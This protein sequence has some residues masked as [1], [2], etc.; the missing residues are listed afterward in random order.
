ME[1]L[2]N[3]EIENDIYYRRELLINSVEGRRIDLL[4][5]SSFHNIQKEREFHFA[6]LFP[7]ANAIRC[8]KFESKKVIF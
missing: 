5:I 4:T 7:E 1:N 6:D 8:H 2:S 3:L